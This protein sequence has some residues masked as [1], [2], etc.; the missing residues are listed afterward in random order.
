MALEKWLGEGGSW[1]REETKPAL[2]R[3]P[4][5][6]IWEWID[7]DMENRAWHF[8]YRLVPKTH[9]PEEWRASLV[10]SFL[11]R[12]GSHKE[13]RSGLMSN[14]LS[15]VW[16]GPPS[17]HYQAIRDKLLRIKDIEDDENAIRW[18]DEFAGGLETQ[19]EQERMYEEREP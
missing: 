13:V 7:G 19:V 3:I 18:I 15:G 4:R 10:R 2:L 12:Y 8:A 14:Y 11:V 9:S 17:L 16:H 6:L 5:K 1:G